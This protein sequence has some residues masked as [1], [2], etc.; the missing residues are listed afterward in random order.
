[1]GKTKEVNGEE[2]RIN[3]LQTFPMYEDLTQI[4]K[5][6]PKVF[7][8]DSRVKSIYQDL[9]L[10]TSKGVVLIGTDGSGKTALVEALTQFMQNESI[11]SKETHVIHIFPQGLE[12]AKTLESTMLFWGKICTEFKAKGVKNLILFFKVDIQALTNWANSIEDYIDTMRD[13]Y[14]LD[15]LKVIIEATRKVSKKRDNEKEYDPNNLFKTLVVWGAGQ[16]NNT[17]KNAIKVLKPRIDELSNF[18]GVSYSKSVLQYFFFAFWDKLPCLEN[19]KLILQNVE[20]LFVLAK[21]K[22]QAKISKKLVRKFFEGDF[23]K[24]KST[25]KTC[26][27][28]TAY[29]EAGHAVLLLEY[30]YFE[31]ITFVK[32]VPSCDANGMVKSNGKEFLGKTTKKV[33]LSKMCVDLA[34]R[35]SEELF[36]NSKPHSG[37]RSDLRRANDEAEK[38][39]M[40]LGFP[41]ILGKNYVIL[42]KKGI[43]QKEL[44]KLEKEKRQLLVEAEKMTVKALMKHEKFVKLLAER[45]LDEY[46]VPGDEVY[47]MWKKYKKSR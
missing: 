43:S 29:H 4:L 15:S 32:V 1:M 10:T 5:E 14:K 18:Y 37:A 17:P 7:T 20:S 13:A 19:Y 24:L 44:R 16:K 41:E 36:C 22:K 38:I 34:G 42:D 8:K 23:Q 2:K 45:L 12:S 21:S 6:K 11:Q 33:A 30:D 3:P 46:I 26:L 27:K 25:S 40:N 39:A 47:K 9:S 35:I 31:E 28:R